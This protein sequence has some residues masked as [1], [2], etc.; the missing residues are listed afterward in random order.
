MPLLKEDW[1]N[2]GLHTCRNSTGLNSVKSPIFWGWFFTLDK[3][4][5]DSYRRKIY[6][7]IFN[8]IMIRSDSC[9][10]CKLFMY[11]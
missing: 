11:C 1:K 9:G 10:K 7:Q 4:D 5:M 8:K 2:S 3:I 6:S